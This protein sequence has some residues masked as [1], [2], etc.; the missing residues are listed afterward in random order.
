MNKSGNLASPVNSSGTDTT[1]VADTASVNTGTGQRPE[2]DPIAALWCDMRQHWADGERLGADT[3]LPRL[4]PSLQ[5]GQAVDLIYAEYVLREESGE[6]LAEC[7]YLSR[8]PQFADA[9]HRQFELHSAL[10]SGA[11]GESEL[12]TGNSATATLP[13]AV[14]APAQSDHPAR[15]GK[16]VVLGRLGRGGQA[17]VFRAV[18]PELQK[19]VVVKL[20]RG[21][22]GK[23]TPEREHLRSEGRL[24]AE[25]DHDA[26]VKVYDLDFEDDRPF[27]VMEYVHARS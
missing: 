9:L 14:A 8:F 26:Y 24:L 16:Y 2:A 5:E 23:G 21:T 11:L 18:H 7:D 10:V 15:I 27:L 13:Q 6:T 22:V 1:A 17:D 4:G 20:A 12:A 3:Y 19:E 25:L